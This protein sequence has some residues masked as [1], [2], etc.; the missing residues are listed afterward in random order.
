MKGFLLRFFGILVVASAAG[1]TH[2]VI[3]GPIKTELAPLPEGAGTIAIPQGPSG[4]RAQSE[5]AKP[6]ADTI[7]QPPSGTSPQNLVLERE[8][9]LDQARLL[10]EHSLADFIDARPKAQYEEGH[11][12]GAFNVPPDAFT[13]GTPPVVDFLDVER[14]VVV[15]CAGGD[16][17]DS[18]VVIEQ[19]MLIRPELVRLHVFTDGY[20]AWTGAGLA[21]DTSPDPL[22]E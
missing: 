19:M 12:P 10:Y 3:S 22:A 14:P 5:E 17:H 8:I 16:C 13:R 9:T 18:H 7:E 4:P 21:T 2:S 6:I 11:I 1:I 20:P 15:Y